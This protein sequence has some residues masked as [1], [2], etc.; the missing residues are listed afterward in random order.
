MATKKDLVEA[1]SFS[2]R[3]LTTAFVSGAPG[4][5]EVE[6]HR[7]MKAVI[8]GLALTVV[9]VLGSLAFGWLRGSLPDNWGDNKLVIAKT[10]G[11]RYVSIKETLHPVLNTTSARLLIPANQFKVITVAD[12]KLATK[13]RGATIGILGAPDSL[14]PPKSLTNSGWVSCLGGQG[15]V[16]TAVGASAK[17][18]P[19]PTGAALVTTGKQTFV[20]AGGMRYPV[21]PGN[22][23]R[24]SQLVGSE[25]RAPQKAPAV[26]TNLF[27]LGPALEPIVLDGYGKSAPGLPPGAAVGTVLSVA[28][29]GQEA[30][31]YLVNSK[32][33]L[34][35]L[36][37]LAHALYRLGS[38]STMREDLEVTPAQVSQLKV[39]PQ[40]I[41][42]RAW[43]DEIPQLLGEAPCATLTSAVGT[44][45]SVALSTSPELRVTP[46][47]EKANVD[48]GTGALVRAVG[49]GS[50]SQGPVLA[51]DQT[52]TSYAIDGSTP[53]LLQRLGYAPG[54]VVPVPQ[55]WTELFRNGP[56]LSVAAAQTT[57]TAA[58]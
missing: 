41:A 2:K 49:A 5:R 8:G 29:S 13:K 39:Q 12:D 28:N 30:R 52:G 32:G 11:A 35:P 55:A 9:L 25:G 15:G 19:S 22:V 40:S 26:W 10:S 51:I 24:V 42:P 58:S 33:E 38:G 57:V 4:G 53:D 44:R 20:I 14:T 17:S 47:V 34:E 27:A 18:E 54:D 16:A 50:L 43:P 6:P 56:V 36:P 1:Q 46:G 23:N 31:R 37:D 3:R 21:S 7:P 45:P 48:L